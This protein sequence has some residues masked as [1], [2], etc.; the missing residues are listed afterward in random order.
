MCPNRKVLIGRDVIAVGVLTFDPC[1]FGRAPPLPWPLAV[2]P[3]TPDAPGNQR[4]LT[5]NV[6]VA[7]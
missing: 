1:P 5:P 6:A 3:P 4:V 2:C 7:R